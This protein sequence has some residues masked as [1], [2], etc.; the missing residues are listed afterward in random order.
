MKVTFPKNIKKGILAGMTLNV[1]P[2]SVTIVQ[3]FLVAVWVGLGLA[4]FQSVS[5]T[6]STAAWVIFALPVLAIFLVMAFLKVSEMGLLEYVAKLFRNKFLDTNKK[7]Q[8]NF[9]KDSQIDVLIK[10]SQT[11]EKKQKIEQKDSSLDKDVLK[12]IEKWGLLW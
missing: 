7:F 9:E 2:I 8:L 4:V 3:L 10:K 1:G 11:R 6:W 12:N 5:K